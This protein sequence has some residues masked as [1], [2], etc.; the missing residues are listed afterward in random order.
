[1]IVGMFLLGCGVRFLDDVM[2]VCG[3]PHSVFLFLLLFP[4]LVK[5][6]DDW[7][8]TLAGIPGMLLVWLFATYLTFR[9]TERPPR[10]PSWRGPS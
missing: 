4:S 6:E 9:R 8:G 2:D 1:M 5:Q 10:T 3:N 7:M